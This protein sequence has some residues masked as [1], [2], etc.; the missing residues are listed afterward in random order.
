MDAFR[1]AT[2]YWVT[3][4]TFVALY[5]ALTYAYQPEPLKKSPDGTYPKPVPS[6]FA[7]SSSLILA[8]NL[9]LAVYSLGT[10]VIGATA[11]KSSFDSQPF[12]DAVCDNGGGRWKVCAPAFRGCLPHARVLLRAVRGFMYTSVSFVHLCVFVCTRL[13][14]VHA[15]VRPPLSFRGCRATVALFTSYFGL[16]APSRAVSLLF[17][18]VLTVSLE[19]LHCT[20]PV[21]AFLALARSALPACCPGRSV[22]DPISP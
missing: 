14:C 6:R 19:N 18:F 8:H 4:A 9:I 3:P 7:P 20:W 2:M 13:R 17:L 15:R 12:W 11:M 1:S 22:R 5:L 21:H 10:F 16:P